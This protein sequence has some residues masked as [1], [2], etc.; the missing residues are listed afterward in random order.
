MTVLTQAHDADLKSDKVARE[1]HEVWLRNVERR[2]SELTAELEY[3]LRE[4]R[5]H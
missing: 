1:F 3:R 4:Q 5:Q 2:V